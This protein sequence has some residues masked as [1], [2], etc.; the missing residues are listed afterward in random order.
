MQHISYNFT[1]S[2]TLREM[3]SVTA[4]ARLLFTALYAVF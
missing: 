3:I 2:Q 4:L 1:S